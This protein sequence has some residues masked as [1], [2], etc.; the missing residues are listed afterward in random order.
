MERLLGTVYR[1]EYLGPWLDDRKKLIELAARRSAETGRRTC[2]VFGPND[3]WYCEPDGR[4]AHSE[5]PPIG[6]IV[7]KNDESQSAE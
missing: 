5:E 3:A 4:R 6:C 2:M 1:Y 7:V